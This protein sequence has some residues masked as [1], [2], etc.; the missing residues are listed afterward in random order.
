MNYTNLDN[1]TAPPCNHKE[2]SISIPYWFSGL[3]NALGL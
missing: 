3:T 2:P 1:P